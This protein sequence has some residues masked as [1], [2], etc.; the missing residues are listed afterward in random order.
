MHRRCGAQ[1]RIDDGELRMENGEWKMK[2][3]TIPQIVDLASAYYGSAILFS[4][5]ELG[6]FKIIADGH[7]T[8]QSI[9]TSAGADLRTMRLLLDG[10]V[11]VGLLTKD[12]EHYANTQASSAALIP[13]SPADLSQAISYNRDV[14]PLWGKLSELVRTGSPV[15]PPRLHLG[16]DKERTRRFALSMRSR[17]FAI[18]RGVVPMLDLSGCVRLLDLAGGPAA[19]AELICRANPGLTC[20]TVDVPAISEIAAE[21]IKE[22][23]LQDRIECRKGDYHTD[24][25]EENA[26]DAVTLFGCLHQESPKSIKDILRRAR[27]ALRP[28]GK[29]FILD[30]MTDATHTSP[31]FSAL[32]GVNMAL[33]MPNGW[34]CSD[35]ELKEWL[36]T[37]GF[38][39]DTVKQVPP[40]MP[41]WLVTAVRL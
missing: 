17:A 11:A 31:S 7:T 32:F 39:P 20:V 4:T 35:E 14:Y 1:L 29:I 27:K 36:R 37:E 15:E 13:G 40:P 18:G 41:H 30:M 26:Y 21:L 25:Y 24:I 28:G 12:G 16:D 19:Y 10:A 33:T 6:I 9:A 38:E 2:A 8:A 34:V 5:L 3:L 23:G 22:A